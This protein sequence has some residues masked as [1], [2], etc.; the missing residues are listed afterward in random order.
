MKKICSM[1]LI[2]MLMFQSLGIHPPTI[3]KAAED[4][5]DEPIEIKSGYH[6]T[7]RGGGYADQAAATGSET[8]PREHIEAKWAGD[9]S[10]TRRGHLEFDLSS[11]VDW[12]KVSNVKLV[13]YLAAHTG[14]G[15]QDTI[16]VHKTDKS[17]ISEENWTWN[18]TNALMEDATVIG[19][20]QFTE[21]DTGSWVEFDITDL[22]DEIADDEI[23]S[24]ALYPEQRDDQGGIKFN[25]QYQENGKYTPYITIHEEEYKDTIPPT[26]HV[27][28]MEN[29]QKVSSETFTFSINVNDNH[30][31]NP[32]V[33][34]TVNGEKK[35]GTNGENT[36]TLKPGQNTI[37]ISA[38]DASG[39][40]SDVK[41]F[42][43]EYEKSLTF[44]A[45]HDTYT[46]VRSP[47]KNFNDSMEKG[48]LQLKNPVSANS[49]RKVYLSFDLSESEL[50]YV[51]NA[52]IQFF[53]YELMGTDRTSEIV[54][55]YEVSDF[56]E[57]EL[58][59]GNAPEN[60]E[61]VADS[62]YERAGS[63]RYVDLD[64]THY[65]NN[66]LA[67]DPNLGRLNF[68]LQVENGHDQKGAFIASKEKFPE[69]SPQLSLTEGLP[70]PDLNIEGIENNAVVTEESIKNV[71]IKGHSVSDKISVDVEVKVNGKKV[72]A[73][74]NDLYDLPLGLG[75]NNIE[76]TAI[77]AEGNETKQQYMVKRLGYV[78]TN[79]YYVDSKSGSDANDGLTEDTPWKSLDKLNALQFKPGTQILFKRGSVWNGQ[80]RPSGSGTS[81]NPIIVGAYGEEESRPII[82]GNGISDLDTGNILAEGAVHLYNISN[83]EINELEVTNEGEENAKASR[84]GIMIYAGGEGFQEHI[85]INNVY[86]HDVNSGI[87]TPK[88]SGGII[89][90]SDTVTEKGEVTNKD[91]GFSDIL[92]ENSHVKNVTFEGLRTKTHKNGQDTGSVKNTDVV[93][94]NNLIEETFGDG[95]VMSEVESGGLIEKNIVRKHSNNKISRNYAGLWLW[96][97]DGVIIQYNEVYDGVNGYNDGEA[98]DFDLGTTNNIYQYNYSHNNRGGLL[99]TMSGAGVGNTFRYNISQN[100]GHSNQETFFV[101]NDRTHIYNNTIYIDEG[102]QVKY[103]V[104]DSG[105][106][107]MFFKNNILHVEGELENYS[108]NSGPYDAPNMANNLIYPAE[109]MELPGS[110][111]PYPGL[112]MEN[113]LLINPGAENEVMDTWDQ[114]IWDRNIANFKLQENSP[115]IDAGTPIDVDAPIENAG[116]YDIYGTPLYQGSPDIGAHEFTKTVLVES[117]T[118]PRD[119]LI[120]ESGKD[121]QLT[122]TVTP[123]NATNKNVEWSSNDESIATV[124]A[125]GLVVA[126]AEGTAIVTVTTIDG[127]Y[128]DTLIVTVTEPDVKPEVDVSELEELLAEVKTYS[129]K[130]GKYTANSFETLENAITNATSA[131][132]SK[133]QA[134]I[135]AAVKSLQS[136]IDGLVE[137]GEPTDPEKPTDPEQPGQN[138]DYYNH[139]DQLAT[140]ENGNFVVENEEIATFTK[141]LIN[142]LDKDKIIH[143]V[144]GNTTINVPVSFIQ[145]YIGNYAYYTISIDDMSKNHQ[146]ALSDVLDIRMYLTNGLDGEQTEVDFNESISL[147]FA[148]DPTEVKNWNNLVLRFIDENGKHTDY[149][150]QI[151]Y[152]KETGEIEAMVYHFSTYGIFEVAATDES[153]DED[154]EDVTID[155]GQ[156]DSDKNN[157]DQKDQNGSKLPATATNMFNVIGLGVLLLLVGAVFVLFRK[158]GQQLHK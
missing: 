61:K 28:G 26:V 23:L 129:N 131:L 80:F 18:N 46:D 114:D 54:N 153:T 127:N 144:Y 39:N 45:I 30:D 132:E 152:N 147:N 87:D 103:F 53:I 50:P 37:E 16:Q 158:K 125:N 126:I 77:D 98:F 99:L 133:E 145:K 67:E 123:E 32:L 68:V 24:L 3:V 100:D 4:K 124:D 86:V 29:N 140:D 96:Y 139:P 11:D 43:V 49:T 76:I 72:E 111:N 34:L 95:I 83:W 81:E 48:G 44:P 85:H 154:K 113:P 110:P 2:V 141:D 59:W 31:E 138:E 89:F 52:A 42:N 21:K 69:N 108:Q 148:I 130:D 56:D 122:A 134:K 151:T 25:S 62:S 107:N 58:T 109:I 17:T 78:E 55:I 101:M 84:A 63:D 97:T 27:D 90:R 60:G 136:A 150:D 149:V 40:Q 119:E 106:D 135:E 65:I 33:H 128:T 13:M 38:E 116:G 1:F 57:Q 137:V 102:V 15:K 79:I 112:V 64:I 146:E 115:A 14:N 7:V 155:P 88:F 94:K 10:Y 12:E 66:R 41:V 20:Q 143:F 75:E 36:V 9:M 70:A 105:I 74:S 35:T 93:F 142:N 47:D 157:N 92:V 118:L 22:K 19:K 82:N 73:K 156:K 5:E 91:S 8:I 104:N 117:V 6:A 120:L 51:K 121:Y 71:S